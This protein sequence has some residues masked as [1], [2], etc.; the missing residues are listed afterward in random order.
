MKRFNDMK[1]DVRNAFL[2]TNNFES[3]PPFESYKNFILYDKLRE[4]LNAFSWGVHAKAIALGREEIFIVIVKEIYGRMDNPFSEN[5]IVD[6]IEYVFSLIKPHYVALL[7]DEREYMNIVEKMLVIT[8]AKNDAELARILGDTPPVI[9]KVR[10]G[11]LPFGAMMLLRLHELTGKS[12]KEL[13]S[14]LGVSL[15]GLK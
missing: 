13:R 11:R 1:R 3:G 5:Y 7:N 4:E 10:S 2:A 15:R 12:T 6:M 8:G 14:T 9:S